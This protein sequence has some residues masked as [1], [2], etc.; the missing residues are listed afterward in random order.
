LFE[1]ATCLPLSGEKLTGMKKHLLVLVGL[2]FALTLEAQLKST[3][4][5][6][7]FTVDILYGKVNTVMASATNGQI[8]NV[9][10]CFSSSEEET[11]EAKCGGT[12]FY[13]D[14]DIYF[15]TSRDYI[16]LGPAF[17]G[18]LS[19]PLMGAARTSLFKW[20]GHPKI[21]D[22]NWDA[23][24]MQYGILIL[25]YSKA[26]KVNKIQISTQTTDNIKLCQ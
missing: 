24:Q 6:P 17:K 25:Y 13:K 11:A 2:L 4:V 18:K 16:E 10:P 12:V 22:A 5:C 3:P 8:K 20:L 15:Y 23:F 1:A 19:L 26:G 9:F 7:A 21:K 14:K